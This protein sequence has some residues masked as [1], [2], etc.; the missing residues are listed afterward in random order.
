MRYETTENVVFLCLLFPIE[1]FDFQD[2][3]IEF[4]TQAVKTPYHQTQFI[5]VRFP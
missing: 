3:K 2:T 1:N 5:R 4:P